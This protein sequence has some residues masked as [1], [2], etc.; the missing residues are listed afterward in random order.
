MFF[1]YIFS[2]RLDKESIVFITAYDQIRYLIARDTYIYKNK[3]ASQVIKMISANFSLK[4]GTIEDTEYIIPY[5][6]EENQTILDIMYTAIELTTK[7]NGRKYILYDDFG[8]ISLKS[9]ENMSF[10]ILID[11]NNSNIDYYYSTSIDKDVYNSIKVSVKNKKTNIISTYTKEDI[12]NKNK[13]GVLRLFERLPND[14][15]K[16]QAENYALNLLNLKNKLK[17][18]LEV[19]YFGNPKIRA[20]Y[21]IN[22]ITEK[23]IVNQMIIDECTHIIYENEHMMKLIL[24]NI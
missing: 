3:T 23:D 10:P 19:Y 1:G 16:A 7:A 24:T 18:K 21:I 13:W 8:K 17:E 4:T 5:R 6:I 11:Y 15:T 14:F 9:Y 12:K 20:G 22:N 2:K